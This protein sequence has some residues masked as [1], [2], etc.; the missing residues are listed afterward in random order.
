VI[1]RILGKNEVVSL[2][3]TKGSQLSRNPCIQDIPNQVIKSYSNIHIYGV[4][5]MLEI[6]E[7]VPFTCTE[8][9]EF[10]QNVIG[11]IIEEKITYAT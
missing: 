2:I 5:W 6:L 4:E 11:P 9:F 1:E 10:F 8:F 7:D 3:L